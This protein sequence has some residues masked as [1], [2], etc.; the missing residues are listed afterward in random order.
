MAH[1]LI[2]LA[3]AHSASQS[4]HTTTLE[5]VDVIATSKLIMEA[6]IRST[7]PE[8]RKRL[9]HSKLQQHKG[10]LFVT[11][12]KNESGIQATE[13]AETVPESK[14]VSNWYLAFRMVVSTHPKWQPNSVKSTTLRHY[15]NTAKQRLQQTTLDRQPLRVLDA[16]QRLEKKKNLLATPIWL[17]KRISCKTR[18]W[19]NRIVSY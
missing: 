17:V 5:A 11:W 8:L 4:Q 18:H 13:L 3:R 2:G 6:C 12:C 14:R 7:C 16:C 9:G 15:A 19:S 1:P 10:T